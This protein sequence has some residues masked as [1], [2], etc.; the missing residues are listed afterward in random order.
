MNA[1]EAFAGIVDTDNILLDLF[2]DISDTKMLDLLENLFT[3]V[4]DNNIVDIKKYYL[5]LVKQPH[6]G[7]DHFI[8]VAT[9]MHAVL[10]KLDVSNIDSDRT[11]QIIDNAR[12][13]LIDS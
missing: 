2:K 1:I 12:I 13:T 8:S 11:M 4:F 3:A 10:T 7:D 5:E 9:A 6:L